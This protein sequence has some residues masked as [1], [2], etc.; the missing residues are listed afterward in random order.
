MYMYIIVSF[1]VKI[2]RR[3]FA[4]TSLNIYDPNL[5]SAYGKTR[6]TAIIAMGCARRI[7]DDFNN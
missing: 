4:L 1:K 2:F 6:F 5:F 7:R 3:A